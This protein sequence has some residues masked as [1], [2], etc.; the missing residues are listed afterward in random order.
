MTITLK[1]YNSKFFPVLA[2]WKIGSVQF[3]WVYESKEEAISHLSGRFGKIRI[4]NKIQR[5]EG[6]K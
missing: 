6:T 5:K 3:E 2:S 1:P 4:I